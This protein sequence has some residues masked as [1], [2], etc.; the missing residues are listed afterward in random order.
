[1]TVMF[2]W[3]ANT[4]LERIIRYDLDAYQTLLETLFNDNRG[5]SETT[6]SS[7]KLVLTRSKSN[8]EM[9]LSLQG[10]TD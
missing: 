7:N 6:K 9:T 4:V 5:E 3:Q 2:L 8:F 1:M 10:E